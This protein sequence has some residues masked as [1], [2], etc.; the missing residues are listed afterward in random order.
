MEPEN[1]PTQEQRMLMLLQSSYPSWV[2]ATS[3][4]QISLQYNAR[5]FGLRRKGWQIANKVEVQPDGTK[6]GSFRLAQPMSWPNPK[7]E[8]QS[9]SLIKC[10]PAQEATGSLFGDL[11]QEHR[12]DG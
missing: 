11:A 8:N 12:D 5:I 7:Q 4:A 1:N 3:L 6:H 10:N 9:V 2:P